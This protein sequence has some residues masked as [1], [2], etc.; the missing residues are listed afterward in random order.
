MIDCSK[1]SGVRPNHPK[2]NKESG[3]SFKTGRKIDFFPKKEEGT[4]AGLPIQI[5]GGIEPEGQGFQTLPFLFL[6]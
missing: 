6:R 5:R 1:F 4:P 3:D 2:Q